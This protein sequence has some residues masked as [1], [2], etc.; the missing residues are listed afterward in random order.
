MYSHPLT[1]NILTSTFLMGTGDLIAQ[2]LLCVKD[3][4]FNF[5][6]LS[7]MLLVGA[8]YMGPM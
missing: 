4:S 3:T 2:K 6:R 7:R 1:T 5:N 8:L